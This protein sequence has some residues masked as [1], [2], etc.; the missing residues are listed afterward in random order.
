MNVLRFRGFLFEDPSRPNS[1]NT[2]KAYGA[3]ETIYISVKT[4]EQMRAVGAGAS[5]STLE[6][7]TGET[8]DSN[9]II[10]FRSVSNDTAVS[11]THL[12]LPTILLV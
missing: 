7:A 9:P 2:A 3:G 8:A 4:N 11:Y 6:L 10:P 5:N 1:L 12:T